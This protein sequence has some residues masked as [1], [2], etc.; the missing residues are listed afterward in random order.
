M[1]PHA[2]VA[3][4]IALLVLIALGAGIIEFGARFLLT[5]GVLRPQTITPETFGIHYEKVRFTTEDGVPIAGWFLAS[6]AAS[7]KAI[8]LCH[9]WGTNKGEI[10]EATR[11]L[12]ERYNLLYF[13][14]R[15]CG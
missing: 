4:L 15:V 1:T 2:V 5:S 7:D 13:D 9:G 14:F 6:K 3:G 11:F 8:I 10:L 12:S